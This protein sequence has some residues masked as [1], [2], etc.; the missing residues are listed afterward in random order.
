MQVFGKVIKN[1]R[2]HLKL[3]KAQ[4]A[5]DYCSVSEL[6]RIEDHNHGKQNVILALC[7]QLALPYDAVIPKRVLTDP[8]QLIRLIEALNARHEFK[9]VL[10]LLESYLPLLP[11]Q[12]TIQ[13]GHLLYLKGYAEL[14][15]NENIHHV[16]LSYQRALNLVQDDPLYELLVLKGI[17]YYYQQ[18]NEWHRAKHYFDYA[19][20][21]KNRAPNTKKL[22]SLY[23]KS[24]QFYACIGE[25]QKAMKLC[26]EGIQLI[27]EHKLTEGLDLL[28][29]EKALQQSTKEK[30]RVDLLEKADQYARINRN[31]YLINL[32]KYWL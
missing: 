4:A 10:S 7:H 17:A 21:M 31:F 28:Y 6:T 3:T 32:L 2:L 5:C 24:S 27:Q 23:Y 1:Q 13:A 15:A 8:V 25:A 22:A 16:L 14:H 30:M 19:L 18:N 26:D 11:V 20:T 9:S 12:D 29:F